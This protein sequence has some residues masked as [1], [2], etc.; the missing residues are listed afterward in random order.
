M[1]SIP[2]PILYVVW[3]KQEHKRRG[4]TDVRTL[5]AF[6]ELSLGNQALI[7]LSGQQE[8][9]TREQDLSVKSEW[10]EESQVDRIYFGWLLRGIAQN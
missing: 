4:F 5:T 10:N 2:V 7:G 3:P 1:V 8:F 9:I 6:C